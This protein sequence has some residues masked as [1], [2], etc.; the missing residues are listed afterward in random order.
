MGGHEMIISLRGTNGSGKST[1]VRA[2]LGDVH[3]KKPIW[4][5]GRRKPLGYVA[6]N[7]E[8]SKPLF[9]PGHYEIA[10][11]G[12][13]TIRDIWLVYDLIKSYANSGYHVMYEGKN[14]TDGTKRLMSLKL[15]DRT[16]VVIVDHP[17]D[18][19]IKSVRERG[20]KIKEETIRKI[21]RKVGTDAFVFM[22]E[23]FTVQR[24]SR[25]DALIACNALLRSHP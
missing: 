7:H 2:I 19:C 13:D 9:I 17:I 5:D 20:H 18:D 22:G 3:E 23:G 4:A 10:N 16:T 12:I 6:I 25:E 14:L 21:A 24:L 8:W 1:I 11:G 15:K